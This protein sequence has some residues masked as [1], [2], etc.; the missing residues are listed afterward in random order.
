MIQTFLCSSECKF[1]VNFIQ[2]KI[3][4]SVFLLGRVKKTCF[5]N[6]RGHSAMF[7]FGKISTSLD[8]AQ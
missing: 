5:Q 8:I 4:Y 1:D 6:R 3:Y 2:V 7:D